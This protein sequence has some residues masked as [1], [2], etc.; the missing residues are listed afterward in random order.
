ML[1]YYEQQCYK[2]MPH[3]VEGR[4]YN[5]VRLKLQ[6]EHG[7]SNWMD[8]TPSQFKAIEKILQNDK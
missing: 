5:V 4:Y 8:L 2:V 1:N 7:Q 6:S 3:T